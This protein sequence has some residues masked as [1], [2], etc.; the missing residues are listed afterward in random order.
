MAT[1]LQ[2]TIKVSKKKLRGLR[3]KA[4]KFVKKPTNRKY[5]LIAV[6]VVV[7]YFAWKKFGKTTTTTTTNPGT[8]EPTTPPPPTSP[9]G[10]TPGVVTP[11]PPGNGTMS[12]KLAD[13]GYPEHLNLVVVGT[14][15]AWF[16]KDLSTVTAPNG[17][18]IRY[19][20][21]G[22]DPITT[23]SPLDGWL[24]ESNFPVMVQ[25]CLIKDGVNE[26]YFWGT[27]DPG[28]VRIND[29]AMMSGNTSVAYQQYIFN[30]F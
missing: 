26:L 21:D 18:S 3:N 19:Y 24:W 25:K 8:R 27:N 23:N 30:R 7:F 29:G 16:F 5:F 17:Y 1:K 9:G 6:A 10:G 12:P 4:I 14:S 20:I 13:F 22:A 28:V 15:G 2:K 11:Y